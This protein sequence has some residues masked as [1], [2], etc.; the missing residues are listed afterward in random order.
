[1]STPFDSFSDEHN[2]ERYE[3]AQDAEETPPVSEVVETETAG[4]AVTLAVETSSEAPV[5]PL[6]S[7]LPRE[8]QGE[9][10]GGPLGCCLGTV[11]GLFLTLLVILFISV[12]IGNGGYL[13]WATGP[14]AL[15]GAI[16]GGYAGWRIG[17]LIYRE[18]ELSP[19][20]RE[21]L[22]RAEQQ[23]RARQERSRRV[24]RPKIG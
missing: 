3:P 24:H 14:I 15:A 21:R 13:G 16:A 1:M 5:D 7:T 8:A 10:N 4:E 19:Q 20:R 23:W 9:A 18:Y 2:E 17:K 11:A 22:E 6:I 12:A